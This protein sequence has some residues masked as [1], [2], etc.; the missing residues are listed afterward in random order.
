MVIQIRPDVGEILARRV[1]PRLGAVGSP[2]FGD[3]CTFHDCFQGYNS[4][5]SLRGKIRLAEAQLDTPRE[6]AGSR[7]AMDSREGR[8]HRWWWDG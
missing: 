7:V 2:I 5:L 6:G 3:A 8:E 1:E 4:P